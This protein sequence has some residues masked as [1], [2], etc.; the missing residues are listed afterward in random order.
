LQLKTLIFAVVILQ[1]TK[2]NYLLTILIC[3]LHVYY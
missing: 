3:A 1:S 2:R